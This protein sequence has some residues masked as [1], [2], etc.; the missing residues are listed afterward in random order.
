M[1]YKE[2]TPPRPPTSAKVALVDAGMFEH[3]KIKAKTLIPYV[4]DVA[5]ASLCPR[6]RGRKISSSL[7]CT[8][9]PELGGHPH[10]SVKHLNRCLNYPT[11]KR[12]FQGLSLAREHAEEKNRAG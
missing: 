6:R 7:S 4:P 3:G 5:R 8:L 10:A 12:L 2:P 9:F 1:G 11:R